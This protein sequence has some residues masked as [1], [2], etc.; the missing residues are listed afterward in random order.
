V[1]S[2]LTH[3]E[4]QKFFAGRVDTSQKGNGSSF[5][6]ETL[7]GQP[8]SVTSDWIVKDLPN[9]GIL[10]FDYACTLRPQIVV[11]PLTFRRFRQ[12]LKKLGLKCV[13]PRPGGMDRHRKQK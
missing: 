7:N 5:R 13:E 4:A 9:E 10:R 11:P 3:T 1:N 6:N 8:L 12:L 2:G